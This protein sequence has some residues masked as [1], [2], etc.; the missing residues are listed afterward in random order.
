MTLQGRK[1][2]STDWKLLEAL[3]QDGRISY[4]ELGQKIGLSTPA[5]SERVR[6]LEDSGVITG[7]GA[8]L[9]LAKLDRG[10]TAFVSVNTRPESNEPL[11]K[12]VKKTA[13][14]L[15]AHYITG[16]A[17]FILKISLGSIAALEDF[18]KR[19][20][21]FGPTQTSIVLSTHVEERVITE[22][23]WM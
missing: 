9:D 8:K 4:R 5:V 21:H 15:E 10:I 13:E 18:I 2:D 3:Q 14:V 19:L 17:S 11:Q 20:S 1:L 23:A 16:Q 6:K 7:Y 12:F 22:E